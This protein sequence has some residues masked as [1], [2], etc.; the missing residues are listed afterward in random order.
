M[1]QLIYL[2]RYLFQTKKLIN[3]FNSPSNISTN[4]LVFHTHYRHLEAQLVYDQDHLVCHLDSFV[5]I[6]FCFLLFLLSK[7]IHS[8]F[9]HV[10]SKLSK[11]EHFMSIIYFLILQDQT[12]LMAQT[13]VILE[14]MFL[15]NYYCQ[16]QN[17]IC[18]NYLRCQNLFILF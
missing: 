3:Q 10:S 15:M 7:T 4:L 14:F 5:V 18:K 1:D 2:I 13:K 11:C 16:N 9:L 8:Y 17:Q 6:M 12:T